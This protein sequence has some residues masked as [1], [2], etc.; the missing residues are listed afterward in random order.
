MRELRISL[1]RNRMTHLEAS[2]L[3]GPSYISSSPSQ[4]SSTASPAAM[5]VA[6]GAVAVVSAP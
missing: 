2:S 4:N 6:R 3:I 1:T 5:A